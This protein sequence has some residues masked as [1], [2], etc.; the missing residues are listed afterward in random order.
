MQNTKVINRPKKPFAKRIEPWL[1]LA[2]AIIFFVMFTY[3]PFIKTIFSSF[4]RVNSMGRMPYGM[5][6]AARRSSWAS[7]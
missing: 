2:P 5:P 6:C 1:Y 3:Y 7:R 4:F